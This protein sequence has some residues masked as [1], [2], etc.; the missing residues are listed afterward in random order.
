MRVKAL[1][2]TSL[3]ALAACGGETDEPGAV[4]LYLDPGEVQ[5]G[6]VEVGQRSTVIVSVVNLEGAAFEI[7]SLTLRPRDE[8]T[9]S[10]SVSSRSVPADGSAEIEVVYHP[11]GAASSTVELVVAPVGGAPVAITIRGN[12]VDP[13]TLRVSDPSIDFGAVPVG[14]PQVSV[15]SIRNRTTTP[16]TVLFEP[17]LNVD[18]CDAEGADRNNFCVDFDGKTL[19]DG[20]FAIGAS[21]TVSFTV[22]FQAEDS[23]IREAAQFELSTCEIS[24]DC[25]VTVMLAGSGS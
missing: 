15:S 2:A 1:M 22:T 14:M 8:L 10:H 3:C 19:D 16:G 20:R 11:V 12:A 18:L 4:S 7:E 21:E 13:A 24:T 6:Q 23:G 5:F 25:R 9:F 17:G